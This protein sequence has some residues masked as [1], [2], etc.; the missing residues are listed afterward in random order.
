MELPGFARRREDLAWTRRGRILKADTPDV[1]I[2]ATAGWVSGRWTVVAVSQ[3]LLPAEVTLY[4]SR[5]GGAH[6]YWRN[7]PPGMADYFGYCDAPALMP[8]LIGPSTRAA[9]KL[10]DSPSWAR[11]EH[12]ELDDTREPVALHIRDRSVETTTKVDE[13]DSGVIGDLLAIHRALVE[14]SERVLDD[15]RTAADRLQGSVVT[16]W[17]PVLSVPRGFGATTISLH[18]SATAYGLGVPTIELTADARG[19]RL[20]LI[21]REPTP[22]RASILLADRPFL[23]IGEVPIAHDKLSR[24]VARTDILSITVRRHATI[25]IASHEP[26]VAKF[27]A[28]LD[29]LGE[30]C[31]APAE[32]YR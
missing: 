32:P 10:H 12:G 9:I 11:G 29:L 30:I 24:L 19:A 14:D 1:M 3:L 16:A 5:S 4:V 27:D 2:T 7:A 21:E 20:W 25:R 18:G 13:A 8:I 22:T 17:P 31:A 15:W 26:D 28:L 23:A 6:G